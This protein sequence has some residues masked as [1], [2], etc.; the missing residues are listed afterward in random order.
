MFRWIKY[1]IYFVGDYRPV[2]TV[3]RTNIQ[4]ATAPNQQELPNMAF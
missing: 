1:L 4:P 2:D 3:L